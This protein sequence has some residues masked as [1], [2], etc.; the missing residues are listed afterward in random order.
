MNEA[1]PPNPEQDK[2]IEVKETEKSNYKAW[3]GIALFV[4]FSLLWY[5][6]N[7]KF[8]KLKLLDVKIASNMHD[9]IFEEN[10]EIKFEIKMKTN[11]KTGQIK[12]YLFD[13]ERGESDKILEESF[14]NVNDT[15]EEYKL[16]TGFKSFQGGYHRICLKYTI[17]TKGIYKLCGD[18]VKKYISSET[19]EIDGIDGEC[20]FTCVPKE[21]GNNNGEQYSLFIENRVTGKKIK[22]FI[23]NPSKNTF[24][25][26]QYEVS[27]DK[28]EEWAISN[29]INISHSN[30]VPQI[31]DKKNIKGVPIFPALMVSWNN[32]Q[33]YCEVLKGRLPTIEEWDLLKNLANISTDYEEKIG[34]IMKLKEDGYDVYGINTNA[35]EWSYETCKQNINSKSVYGWQSFTS[36]PFKI[37][38]RDKNK[39]F[40]D[41]G[42]RCVIPKD[43][44]VDD[45]KR[46]LN[47]TEQEK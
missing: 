41:I 22:E 20:K 13:A 31:V 47:K 46:F 6:V 30:L 17:E 7:D 34:D 29:G 18:I 5:F 45:L 37:E 36:E 26:M 28:Y 25:I 32:A 3:K 39:Q 16:I 11:G 10:D 43:S 9:N 8:L 2:E 38:C 12:W 23:E 4:I 40:N 19:Q 35:A 21:W 33:K 44:I 14:I 27:E 1:S 42:F 24:Y 15:I